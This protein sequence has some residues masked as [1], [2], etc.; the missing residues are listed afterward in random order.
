MKIAS[1]SQKN[2]RRVALE[3]SNMH[4]AEDDNRV[5]MAKLRI[6]IYFRPSIELLP[7]W[8][9]DKGDKSQR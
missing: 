3:K 2:S 4:R 1:E 9:V 5:P 8:T 6:Q 7:N